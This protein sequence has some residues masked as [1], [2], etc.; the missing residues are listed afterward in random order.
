MRVAEPSSQGRRSGVGSRLV[1]N[2]SDLR[3]PSWKRAEDLIISIPLFVA[4]LP[5][6][7]LAGIA[8]LVDDGWPLVFWDERVG[9]GGKTFRVAKLRTMVRDAGTMGLGRA[10]SSDDPRITRTGR[11]LRRFSLDELPQIWSILAGDMSF[12]GPRPTVADQVRRYGARDL[13]RLRVKPGLTGLAQVSGRN[14]L[15]WRERIERDLEYVRRLS[16]RLDIRILLRT[17]GVVL[18]GTG[19]YG[20]SGVTPD[21][22]P[23]ED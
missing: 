7:L 11:I 1:A 4:S 13:G 12:I 3:T 22:E 21:Y 23:E 8:V 9:L 20:R 16:V 17:P 18:R 5:V 15:S 6:L 14:D 19:L 10:V 2:V